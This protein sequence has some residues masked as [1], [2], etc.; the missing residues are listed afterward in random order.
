MPTGVTENVAGGVG[1]LPGV[2][3]VTNGERTFRRGIKNFFSSR[4]PA[5]GRPLCV[6]RPVFIMSNVTRFLLRRSQRNTT[7][8]TRKRYVCLFVVQGKRK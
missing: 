2:P 3:A 5:L 1:V 4:V 7:T 6:C 8:P